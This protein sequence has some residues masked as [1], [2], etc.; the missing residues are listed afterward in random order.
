MRSPLTAWQ[1]FQNSILVLFVLI[2]PS[3]MYVNAAE[4]KDQS[5]RLQISHQATACMSMP[6]THMFTHPLCTTDMQSEVSDELGSF[7]SG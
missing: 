7:I 2:R 5:R 1:H 4:S 6:H 3:E